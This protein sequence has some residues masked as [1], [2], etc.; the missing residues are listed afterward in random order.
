MKLLSILVLALGFSQSSFANPSFSECVDDCIH[1]C[2]GAGPLHCG[3]SYPALREVCLARCKKD[4]HSTDGNP[5]QPAHDLGEDVMKPMGELLKAVVTSLPDGTKNPLTLK[6]LS[7]LS[8]KIDVAIVTKPDTDAYK[9]EAAKVGADA[10][11]IEY[12]SMLKNLKATVLQLSSTLSAAGT[13][14]CGA[15]CDTIIG[16][17]QQLKSEGHSAF[18]D[19]DAAALRTKRE[20]P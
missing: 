10:A 8:D 2:A 12:Q 16:Q 7:D 5:V 9:K 4:N 3:I 18:K 14:A 13:R 19:P 20:L 11:L 15:N 6:A 17:I 1:S